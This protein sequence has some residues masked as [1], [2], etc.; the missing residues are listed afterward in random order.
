[1]SF[2]FSI[3]SKLRAF[4]KTKNLTLNQLASI[5]GIAASNISAIELGKSSPTLNTLVKFAH[6]FNMKVSDLLEEA[7]Y[8]KIEVFPANPASESVNIEIRHLS[9]YVFLREL[10]IQSLNIPAMKSFELDSTHDQFIYCLRGQILIHEGDNCLTLAQDESCYLRKGL[11]VS[12][13][14]DSLVNSHCL[15]VKSQKHS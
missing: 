7:L 9:Q 14:S 15:I 13:S 2:D 3:G 6:A 5:T 11:R 1:M 8:E 12:I 10:D 4:R